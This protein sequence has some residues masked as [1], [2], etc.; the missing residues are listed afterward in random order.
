MTPAP[1]DTVPVVAGSTVTVIS[2]STLSPALIQSFRVAVTTP[3]LW[4]QDP[5]AGATTWH[6]WNVELVGIVSVTT[7][8]FA[9]PA[10]GPL[11]VFVTV[12]T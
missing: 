10:V 5:V 9:A 4:L 1:F 11:E 6:P 3:A 12:V 2:T 8:E 7:T